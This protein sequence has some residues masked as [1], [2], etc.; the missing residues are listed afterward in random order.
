MVCMYVKLSRTTVICVVVIAV[1]K[2]KKTK[3]TNRQATRNLKDLV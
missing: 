1:L 2:K 3:N